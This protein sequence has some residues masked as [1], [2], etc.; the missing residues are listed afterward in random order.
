MSYIVRQVLTGKRKYVMYYFAFFGSELVLIGINHLL[1]G[2]AQP[3]SSVTMVFA[4]SLE[5]LL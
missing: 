2:E 3:T 5:V 4:R 1:G